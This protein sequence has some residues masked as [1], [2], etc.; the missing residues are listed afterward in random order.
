MTAQ[1]RHEET[2]YPVGWDRTSELAEME[3]TSLRGATGIML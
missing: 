3:N 2:S 1:W